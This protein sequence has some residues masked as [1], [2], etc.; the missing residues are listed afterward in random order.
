EASSQGIDFSVDYSFIQKDFWTSARANFTYATS[1]YEVLEEADYASIGRPWSSAIGRNLS[2]WSGYIAERLFIDE[3]DIANSP[4]HTFGEYMA[5]DIKYKDIN[6]DGKIT[7]ADKVY[8][9]YPTTPE[10]TYGFGFSTGY[11]GF[12]LSMF[13][14]GNA[15]VSF[16]LDPSK[17][18]PF[19]NETALIE[20]IATDHWSEDNKN[21]YAF[22]PRLAGGH[23]GNNLQNS[24]WW[25]QDGTF[26]RMKT[27]ELGYT[28]PKKIVKSIGMES[29]RIYL[30]GN[31]L[32]T[33]SKF[34]LWDTEMG[35][36]G[37]GYPIQRVYNI[38]LNINF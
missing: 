25:M 31:N 32:F 4:L 11:K 14:Q 33:M 36:N 18:A 27:V 17:I 8:F 35:S 19:V 9:G 10:I 26:I 7:D 34:K 21:L 37:L 1:K 38:G 6:N 29:C 30:T 5:G 2:Q 12:D 3:N 20:K 15:R 13:F 23:I 24:T 22:W 16:Y 28:L